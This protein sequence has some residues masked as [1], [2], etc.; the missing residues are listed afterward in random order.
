MATQ[1]IRIAKFRKGGDRKMIVHTGCPSV[2]TTSTKPDIFSIHMG[3][4]N[5]LDLDRV[6]AEWLLKT[7]ETHL[8][9]DKN[10]D[11]I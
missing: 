11:T 9:D 8:R 1:L 7:L 4:D 3:N 2:G 5:Q 10:H 6:D